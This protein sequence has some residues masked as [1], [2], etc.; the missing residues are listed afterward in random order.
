MRRSLVYSAVLALLV[1]LFGLGSQS[2]ASEPTGAYPY[3]KAATVDAGEDAG[4]LEGLVIDGLDEEFID[5]VQVTAVEVGS[6]SRV[7]TSL[8]YASQRKRGP[9]HGYYFLVV[10]PGTYQV[11][12]EREGFEPFQSGRHTVEAAQT[13]SV[14]DVV[15][16][17]VPAVPVVKVKVKTTKVTAGEKLKVPVKVVADEAALAN[18]GLE[19]PTGSVM[20]AEVNP[21]TGKMKKKGPRPSVTRSEW[22]QN[23]VM[24]IKVGSK[25]GKRAFRVWFTSTHRYLTDAVQEDVVKV[26]VVAPKKKRKR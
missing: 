12:F 10:P 17:R 14:K 22:V 7:A 6:Q 1:G 13:V 15:I 20:V 2:L 9:Q 5:D 16:D 24:R 11:I 8:S 25:T 19:Y 3:G 18:A 21:K 23:K 26:R 4:R